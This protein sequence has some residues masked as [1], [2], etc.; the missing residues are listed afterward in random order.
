MIDEHTP[1]RVD[2]AT[3][4]PQR[5]GAVVAFVAGKG[6]GV[7]AYGRGLDERS[8]AALSAILS[9]GLAGAKLGQVA[10]QLHDANGGTLLCAVGVG[11]MVTTSAEPFRDAA[12]ALAKVLRKHR[13]GRVVVLIDA[14]L[15]PP[16]HEIASAVTSGLCTGSFTFTKFKGTGTRN[17]AVSRSL[18]VT[19][20]VQPAALKFAQAA[21]SRAHTVAIAQN[22]ARSVAAHPGNVMHP[23]ALAELARKVAKTEGLSIRVLDEKHMRKLGMGGMLAVGMGSHP[24]PPRMI[25]LEWNGGSR[26]RSGKAQPLLLVG[27]AIT[28]DTGGISI[29]PREG[30][31]RMVFDKCGAMAVLGT[32]IA[33]ARLKLP[34]RVVGI[35]ATAENHVSATAYRPGDILTM[36]NGVTVEVTNTDA[37][38]RLVLADALAWGIEQYKPAAVVD[39]ATLTGG[40]V[41][42]LGHEFAGLMS[43]SDELS[44]ALR[45]AGEATGE[46]IWRLPL[47]QEV[48]EMMKSEHADIVNSAGRF[49]HALQGGEFLRR[50]IPEDGVGVPWAHLD[51]AGV[52]D[53]EK[54]SHQYT[55]GATGW[56]V[57]ILVQWLSSR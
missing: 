47:G 42:S 33:V 6:K 51:I 15:P 38:G 26:K 43:T 17:D 29:K 34:A 35:L 28:F 25:V 54:G 53:S 52:A 13:I 20:V 2:V 22:F 41:V 57:R 55:S 37:E 14:E 5:V 40:V 30:M 45:R 36:Y 24:T 46:K 9:S 1:V 16:T 56:G 48:R 4:L 10:C 18:Q 21:V 3:T 49:A 12:G 8:G 44:E 27:K 39:L 32:L 50:F 11:E 31:Q 23:P 19:L 7:R